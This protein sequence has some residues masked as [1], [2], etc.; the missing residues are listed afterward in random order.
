[1]QKIHPQSK[2]SVHKKALSMAQADLDDMFKKG[3]HKCLYITNVVLPGPLSPT[4][5]NK[6][7]GPNDPKPPDA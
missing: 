2:R 1:M 7:E 4:P 6:E 3:L 5:E